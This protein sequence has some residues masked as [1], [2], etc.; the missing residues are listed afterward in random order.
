MLG[1]FCVAAQLV[2]SQEGLSS[3]KFV[4]LDGDVS[5]LTSDVVPML[6]IRSGHLLSVAVPWLMR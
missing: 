2:A 4:S 6:E 5:I 1:S 3:M